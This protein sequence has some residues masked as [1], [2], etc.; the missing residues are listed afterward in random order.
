MPWASTPASVRVALPRGYDV[1]IRQRCRA[2]RD[3]CVRIAA[4]TRIWPR[5]SK[6]RAFCID[7]SVL[8][9]PI[10]ESASNNWIGRV[11]L[12]RSVLP[13]EL[14]EIPRVVSFYAI[15]PKSG[16]PD[17]NPGSGSRGG[18]LFASNGSDAAPKEFIAA[19]PCDWIALCQGGEMVE[20]CASGSTWGRG[21]RDRS[22]SIKKAARRRLVKLERTTGFEPAT[23]TLARSCSTS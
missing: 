10:Q 11:C 9:G 7:E 6:N 8:S 14:S 20:C 18:C 3:N 21:I 2:R 12:P 4:R 22:G 23:P 17:L 1:C 19:G 13:V 15:S 5:R 16:L